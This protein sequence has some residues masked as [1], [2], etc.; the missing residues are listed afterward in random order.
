MSV[1]TG[2]TV[3]YW[4][5][6]ADLRIQS[7]ANPCGIH[8]GESET[9]TDFAHV[10]WLYAVSALQQSWTLI[11]IHLLRTHCNVR[12]CNVGTDKMLVGAFRSMLSMFN[13]R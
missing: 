6:I 1:R 7:Q 4:H 9:R 13:P 8:D 12:N 10:F 5:F 3:P 2:R 11:L